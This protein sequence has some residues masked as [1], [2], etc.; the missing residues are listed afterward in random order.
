MWQHGQAP[1]FSLPVLGPHV[2]NWGFTWMGRMMGREVLSVWGTTCA[3]LKKAPWEDH[4]T[5][6]QGCLPDLRQHGFLG[7]LLVGDHL[8]TRLLV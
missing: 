2:R 4:L 7:L 8:V 5:G 6:G 1:R 3:A